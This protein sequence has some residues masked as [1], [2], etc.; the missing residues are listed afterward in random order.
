MND[1]SPLA[2]EFPQRFRRQF[3][4][5]RIVDTHYLKGRARGI[6]QRPREIKEGANPDFAARPAHLFH[7]RMVRWGE[8]KTDSDGVNAGG[9]L[10]GRKV[11]P[12]PQRFQNVGAAADAGNGAV[13]V[14]G[15]RNAARRR[16]ERRRCRN[17]EDAK[18]A[19]ACAARIE[20]G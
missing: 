6:R 9:G 17:V 16:H 3:A 14:L 19:A 13:A 2:A 10:R 5:V 8:Q 12:S 7:C 15:D 18:R 1:Q 20:Q 11:N 4:Q